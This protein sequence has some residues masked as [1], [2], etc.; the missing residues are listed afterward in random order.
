MS[1]FERHIR[2]QRKRERELH[3]ADRAVGVFTA[4]FVVGMIALVIALF[5]FHS[6]ALVIVIGALIAVAVLWRL[7]VRSQR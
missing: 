2:R 5:L 6:T 3:Q 4:W 7:L 1:E